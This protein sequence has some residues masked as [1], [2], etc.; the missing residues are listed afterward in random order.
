MMMSKNNQQTKKKKK[1]KKKKKLFKARTAWRALSDIKFALS[2]GTPQTSG[3]SLAANL[4]NGEYL[5]RY[6]LT[7]SE[8][9]NRH[10]TLDEFRNIVIAT[11]P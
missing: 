7:A 1:K 5:P 4:R 8:N 3:M 10:E 2:S 9:S 6:A 11:I